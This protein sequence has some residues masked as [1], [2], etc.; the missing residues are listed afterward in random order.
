MDSHGRPMM[1][2]QFVILGNTTSGF[3]LCRRCQAVDLGLGEVENSKIGK[4]KRR[5]NT[6][7]NINIAIENHHAISG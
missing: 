3:P 2:L 7:E 6:H 1:F 4:I 5:W